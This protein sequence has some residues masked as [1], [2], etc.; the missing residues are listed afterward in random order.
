MAASLL[1]ERTSC[2]TS[3]GTY[4]Q[5]AQ[6]GNRTC[7]TT[8]ACKTSGFSATGYCPGRTFNQGCF[9]Q[10]CSTSGLCLSI[11][12]E[13]LDGSCSLKLCPGH[14]RIQCCLKG[15]AGGKGETG[16]GNENG[17]AVTEV[18][19]KELRVGERNVCGGACDVLS[20]GGI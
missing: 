5:P 7:M 17:N 13:C 11:R 2:N 1:E 18:G 20:D 10:I 6:D 12:D 3:M 4:S 16:N 14:S 9:K 15:G 8:R 19:M